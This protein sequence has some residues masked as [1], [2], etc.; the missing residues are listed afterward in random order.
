M[1]LFTEIEPSDWVYQ[2]RLRLEAALGCTLMYPMAGGRFFVSHLGVFWLDVASQRWIDSMGLA[3]RPQVIQVFTDDEP[4]PDPRM[5]PGLA[6]AW[7]LGSQEAMEVWLRGWGDVPRDGEPLVREL[8]GVFA[9]P[10]TGD[11][12]LYDSL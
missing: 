2:T 11:P 9:C 3:P 8:D 4:P 12:E 1:W 10:Y 5:P 7:A 6:P